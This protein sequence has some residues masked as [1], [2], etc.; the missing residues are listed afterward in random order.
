MLPASPDNPVWMLT[1]VAV[2]SV[3]KAIFGDCSVTKYGQI[4]WEYHDKYRVH[5]KHGDAVVL[6]TPAHNWVYVCNAEASEAGFG[7]SCSFQKST[8]A[9]KP[10]HMFNYRD[11]L[12]LILENIFLILIFGPKFLTNRFLPKS[13]IRVGQATV[14]FKFHMVEM[15]EEEKRLI[16]EGKPGGGNII[17]SLIRAS[18]EMSKSA[19]TDESDFKGLTEDEIY[20]NIFVY[21]FAG[22]DTMAIT[23]NWALYLLV[24]HPEIQDWVSQE[25]NTV[26]QNDQSSAWTYDE[27]YPKLNRCLAVLVSKPFSTSLPFHSI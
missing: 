25:I 19:S 17:N 8:E 7:K 11:S 2:L 15:V 27:V 10:G 1:S 5:V 20:G 23:L 22:H 21:N 4:G 13:W 3:V 18:E 14:D 24:A 16:A 9:P 6:V 12:A 26:I